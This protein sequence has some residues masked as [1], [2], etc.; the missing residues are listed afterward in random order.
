LAKAKSLP[1]RQAARK[2]PSAAAPSATRRY[3]RWL[4]TGPLGLLLVVLLLGWY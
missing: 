2:K 4:L 3:A 1:R